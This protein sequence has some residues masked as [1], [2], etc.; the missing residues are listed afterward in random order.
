MLQEF[1]FLEQNYLTAPASHVKH[2]LQRARA[3][4]P[5][6]IKDGCVLDH[7]GR[8]RKNWWMTWRGASHLPPET[9]IAPE[10]PWLEDVFPTEIVNSPF[11][12]AM[13]VSG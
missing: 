10:N 5:V 11:L 9:N 6:P 1:L 3:G 12:G 4:G 8:V 2:R 13:L 7:L